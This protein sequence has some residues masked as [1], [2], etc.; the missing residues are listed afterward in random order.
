M[1]LNRVMAACMAVAM[2]AAWLLPGTVLGQGIGGG[3]PGGG[4]GG[5]RQKPPSRNGPSDG[6]PGGDRGSSGELMRIVKF[7]PADEA[8]D[9]EL[10]GILVVQP[11]R[12]GQKTVTVRIPRKDDTKIT[13]GKVTYEAERFAEMLT[14]GLYC[15]VSWKEE[16]DKKKTGPKIFSGMNFNAV[17]VS[18]TLEKLEGD[19]ATLRVKPTDG[20]EW[21][22]TELNKS[23]APPPAPRPGSKSA[24][25]P[26]QPTAKKV[27][28]RTVKVKVVEELA[29]CLD[30]DNNPVTISDIPVGSNVEAEVV[31]ST[32][33]GL[34]TRVQ[35]ADATGGKKEPKEP[36]D[37]RPGGRPGGKPPGGGI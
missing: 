32:A 36:N 1:K 9:P 35:S 26:P 16:E 34:L 15:N 10:I 11:I 20:R 31:L 29:E 18:G 25:P 19:I 8:K 27:K 21:P 5:P 22:D 23:T 28:M 2:G 24:P 14:K 6:R 13:I 3:R 12:K 7:S 17:K 4:G 33:T 37:G 30:G